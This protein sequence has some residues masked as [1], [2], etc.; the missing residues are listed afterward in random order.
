MLH[1]FRIDVVARCMSLASTLLLATLLQVFEGEIKPSLEE[2]GR[3][4]QVVMVAKGGM[5]MVLKARN[6]CH[7]SLWQYS[8]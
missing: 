4:D 6:G 7:E 5:G 3:F 2:G 1:V 8:K